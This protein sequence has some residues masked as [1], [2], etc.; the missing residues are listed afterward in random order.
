MNKYEETANEI[1]ELISSV[2]AQKIR[3]LVKGET[4]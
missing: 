4:Q 1:I 3:E 2:I